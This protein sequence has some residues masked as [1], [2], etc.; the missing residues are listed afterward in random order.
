[1]ANDLVYCGRCCAATFALWVLLFVCLFFCWV[2]LLLIVCLFVY[3]DRKKGVKDQLS[4]AVSDSGKLS[5]I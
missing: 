5:S 3:V 1:M 4:I 2:L